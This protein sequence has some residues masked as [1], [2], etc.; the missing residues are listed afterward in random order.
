MHSWRC[1]GIQESTFENTDTHL[2]LSA[3]GQAPAVADTVHGLSLGPRTMQK[4][5]SQG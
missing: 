3:G 1:L 5:L 2:R 4:L